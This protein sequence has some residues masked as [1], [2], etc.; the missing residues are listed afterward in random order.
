MDRPEFQL[1]TEGKEFPREDYWLCEPKY[2]GVR[3]GCLLHEDKTVWF[4]RN[5]TFPP[6]LCIEKELPAKVRRLADGIGQH[7]F[8]DGEFCHGGDDRAAY[9]LL[10]RTKNLPL[11]TWFVF[12]MI[13]VPQDFALPLRKRKRA[14]RSIFPEVSQNGFV[15]VA[16]DS[17]LSGTKSPGEFFDQMLAAGMEGMVMKRLDKP[18]KPGVRSRDWL[19]YKA[20]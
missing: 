11:G 12:D 1:A 3:L 13:F 20:K 7:I 17:T 10:S 8:L 9:S 18:Y 14:L 16:Y 2:D 6:K 19:K 15:R 5:E 4:G